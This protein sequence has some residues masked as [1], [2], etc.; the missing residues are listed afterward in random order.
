MYPCPRSLLESRTALRIKHS[1]EEHASPGV[2]GELWDKN[3]IGG[4]RWDVATQERKVWKLKWKILF[5]EKEDT[6]KIRH[7]Y[8]VLYP[9]IL[10]TT[11][12]SSES[13]SSSH[14]AP[15]YPPKFT[16]TRPLVHRQ[17]TAPV[18]VTGI[19]LHP[20]KSIFNFVIDITGTWAYWQ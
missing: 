4:R 17:P 2:S 9:S 7:T 10:Q 11:F 16:S 19:Y 15:Q 14:I 18:L 13:Q 6:S 5:D 8:L 12:A 20:R 1:Q 3:A